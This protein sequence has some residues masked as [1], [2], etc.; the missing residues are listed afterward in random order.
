MG[1]CVGLKRW[2][3]VLPVPYVCALCGPSATKPSSPCRA[4]R[5]RSPICLSSTLWHGQAFLVRPLFYPP[6]SLCPGIGACACE[7]LPLVRSWSGI[8]VV[9]PI[10]SQ[11]AYNPVSRA[12]AGALTP[13]NRGASLLLKYGL[14]SVGPALPES[15]S[16]QMV[17]EVPRC[18]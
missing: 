15:R 10:G 18:F 6:G 11:A 4:I 2:L 9:Q 16:F 14:Y 12:N 5:L 13:V 17:L 1:A 7:E 3:A 8:G